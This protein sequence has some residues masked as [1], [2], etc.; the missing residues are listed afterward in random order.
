MAA[1]LG[2]YFQQR[3]CI[4]KSVRDLPSTKTLVAWLPLNLPLISRRSEVAPWNWVLANS[5]LLCLETSRHE[6]WSAS[7]ISRIRIRRTGWSSCLS[8]QPFGSSP[9]SMTC[10]SQYPRIKQ[11]LILA[12]SMLTLFAASANW[13][14]R[15]NV[16]P[17]NSAFISVLFQ[18]KGLR[19]IAFIKPLSFLRLMNS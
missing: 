6:N 12:E 18:P 2:R 13:A 4:I 3:N 16:I 11:S 1:I 9:G 17:R 5:H 10:T 15:M 19:C 14:V 7:L 8:R